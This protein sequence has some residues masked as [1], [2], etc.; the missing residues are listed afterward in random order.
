MT[1]E[2]PWPSRSV[3]DWPLS[4]LFVVLSLGWLFGFLTARI[5]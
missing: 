2:R 4:R 5:L 1:N 3:I